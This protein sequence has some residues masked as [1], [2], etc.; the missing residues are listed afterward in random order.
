MQKP[1]ESMLPDAQSVLSLEPE[2]LAGVLMAHLNALPENDKFQL[3]R[4]NFFND[5]SRTFGA[6]SSAQ[7]E[8]VAAAFLEAW[9]WLE[10]EG[11]LIPK[12]TNLGHGYTISRRGSRMRTANDMKQYRGTDAL[13]REHLHPRIAQKV[14]ATFLRGYYDTA[15]FQAFKEVEVAVREAARLGDDDLGVDLMR[16]AFHPTTGP[17]TSHSVVKSEREAMG[18]L[19]AGA[20]GVFKNPQSHRHVIL[21]DPREA[22]EM[23]GTASYLLRIVDARRGTI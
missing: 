3:N 19:F 14:W 13:P 18:H 7:R 9:M 20:I 21:K 23:I 8:R 11:F 17:L 5:S 12:V 10:R 1:L 16:Q 15:V 4:Y 2:E 22:A 6:Y